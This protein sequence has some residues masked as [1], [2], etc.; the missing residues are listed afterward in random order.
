MREPQPMN[1]IPVRVVA[2]QE[3]D[4]WIAQCIEYDI[5][6]HAHDLT[7]LSAAFGRAVMQNMCV[8]VDLG[9]HGLEGIPRAPAKFEAMFEKSELTMA[10]VKSR[11]KSR[12][13]ASDPP[14]RIKDWR[15]AP[16]H[17][18]A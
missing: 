9:R 3:G 18:A 10:P 4:F 12:V 16:S 1:H 5:T 11:R 17:A 13:D 6:A 15:L 7:K 2:F 14:V 8:N